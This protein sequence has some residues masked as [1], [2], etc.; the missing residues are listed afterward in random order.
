MENSNDQDDDP[1]KS[2][3]RQKPTIKQVVKVKRDEEEAKKA[4]PKSRNRLPK[5]SNTTT[6]S[7]GPTGNLQQS[8]EKK[9]R[10]Q[11]ITVDEKN[12]LGFAR[13]DFLTPTKKATDVNKISRANFAERENKTE[14]K[15]A[16]TKRRAVPSRK[17]GKLQNSP[18]E[19]VLGISQRRLLLEDFIMLQPQTTVSILVGEDHTTYEATF[20]KLAPKSTMRL[21]LDDPSTS[22]QYSGEDLTACLTL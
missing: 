3:K 21:D 12:H 16:D 17:K 6:R 11:G 22:M 15:K 1:K 7:S 5:Y 19:P 2:H 8:H 4:A 13:A 14:E 18:P 10:N 9:Q 20:S